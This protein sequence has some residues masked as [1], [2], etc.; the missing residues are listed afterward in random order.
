MSTGEVVLVLALTVT[1]ALCAL[2]IIG[3]GTDS[4]RSWNTSPFCNGFWGFA[5]AWL[6]TTC[7]YDGSDDIATTSGEARETRKSLKRTIYVVFVVLVFVYG[8]NNTFLGIALSPS[9]PELGVASPFT[10][11]L[12]SAGVGVAADIVNAVVIIAICCMLLGYP[13][14]QSRMA[15]ELAANGR[16]PAALSG[17]TSWGVPVPALLATMIVSALVY[18]VSLFSEDA[19]ACALELSGVLTLVDWTMV[20]VCHLRF[21]TAYRR[22]HER[23]TAAAYVAPCWPLGQVGLAL[24]CT[25]ILVSSIGS[26]FVHGEILKGSMAL[27]GPVIIVF[28]F[29]VHKLRTKSQ[30]VTIGQIEER[31]LTNDKNADETVNQEERALAP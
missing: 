20:S 3:D 24:V 5:D 10:L 27:A 17:L 19:F 7:A 8:V 18:A 1:L 4:G 9:S 26:S 6:I 12:Q 13:Y 11:V 16:G 14:N 22:V 15:R 29:C 28:V 31:L 23:I 21:R 2:G 30:F 25:V